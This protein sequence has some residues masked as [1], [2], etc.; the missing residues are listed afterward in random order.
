M[1]SLPFLYPRLVR[2]LRG[3]VVRQFLRAYS[4]SHD[5]ASS[6]TTTTTTASPSTVAKSNTASTSTSSRLRVR[7]DPIPFELPPDL[8]SEIEPEEHIDGTI[9][10]MERQAFTK[11]FHDI[12]RSQPSLDSTSTTTPRKDASEIMSEASTEQF[13]AREHIRGER[14]EALEAARSASISVLSSLDKAGSGFT[15]T[16]NAETDSFADIPFAESDA[17]DSADAAR[18]R[19]RTLAA[20]PPSLRTAASEAI[21]S[22]ER[23][24]LRIQ[25]QMQQ[26]IQEAEIEDPVMIAA[27]KK[28]AQTEELRQKRQEKMELVMLSKRTD[29]ALWE[30]METSVFSMVEEFGLVSTTEAAPRDAKETTDREKGRKAAA[31]A[32]SRTNAKKRPSAKLMTYGPVYS[33]TLLHGLKLLGGHYGGGETSPLALAVLPRIKSLGLQSYVLG[34]STP[35]YNELLKIQWTRLG[36]AVA[37]FG[38]LQEMQQAGLAFNDGTLAVLKSMEF[39]FGVARAGAAV[40]TMVDLDSVH[41]PLGT[42]RGTSFVG[43]ALRHLPDVAAVPSMVQWWRSQVE[44]GAIN[45]R[46][47][48]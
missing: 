39:H 23:K 45:S 28:A 41:R 5:T 11:I 8:E 6:S 12:S 7:R 31:K 32:A 3:T 21:G 20:F 9:T 17:A 22:R 33:A 29:A 44:A 38:L 48:A 47:F 15:E 30:Y 18:H 19:Q 42:V 46:R 13:R 27:A 36:D 1:T 4:N 10:P 24:R 35:L 25:Q 14:R 26:Q 37:V 43:A 34:A 2:P 40:S 16:E